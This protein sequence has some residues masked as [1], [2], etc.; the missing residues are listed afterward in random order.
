ML[1]KFLSTTDAEWDRILLFACYCFNTTCTADD[2]ESPFLLVHG[3]DQLEGQTRILGP[4]NIRYLGD[5]KGLIL[6]AEICKSWSANAKSL[7]E[8]RLLK[9]ES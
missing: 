5:H 6:F 2:L 3:R 8:N 7:Q 9:T 1:T 4:G